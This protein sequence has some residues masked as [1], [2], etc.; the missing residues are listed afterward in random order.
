MDAAFIVVREVFKA[1]KSGQSQR[2]KNEWE[3]P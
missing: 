1:E 3:Q 2:S